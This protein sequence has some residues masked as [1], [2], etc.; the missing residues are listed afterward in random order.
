[1]HG[2]TAANP[3]QQV[4]CCGH[5]GQEIS[6]DS[7]RRRLAAATAGECRQCNVVSLCVKLNTDLFKLVCNVHREAEKRNQFSFINKSFI[8]QCNLK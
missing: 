5:G 7:A 1:M 2:P 8:M 4:C 6:I 3:L